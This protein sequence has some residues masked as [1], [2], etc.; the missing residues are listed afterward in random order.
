MAQQVADKFGISKRAVN[1]RRTSAEAVI[2]EEIDF[3][4]DTPEEL[5][6]ATS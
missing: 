5:S 3:D 4:C 2:G 1:M 6:A